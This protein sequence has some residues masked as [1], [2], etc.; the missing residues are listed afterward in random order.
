M[1]TIPTP[2]PDIIEPDTAPAET[3]PPTEP[4]PVP[5]DPSPPEDPPTPPDIVEP[6]R[7]PDEMPPEQ[8]GKLAGVNTQKA[9]HG[10]R[11]F[12]IPVFPFPFP[13]N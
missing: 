1:A 10:E 2:G 5:A 13:T 11:P 9:A 8:G 7:G 3:P 4:T 6:G 12:F